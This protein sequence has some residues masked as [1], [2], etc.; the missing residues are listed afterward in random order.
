MSEIDDGV[1]KYDRN[2]YTKCD[3]L[4]P[5]E[6]SALEYWREKLYKLKL[7]GEYQP[8]MIGYGNVSCR[9]QKSDS[10][11]VITG[12][13]TGKFE[14][15]CGEH[16]TR[17]CGYDLAKNILIANGPL[18]ASSEALTHA[19][20]YESSNQI[21]AVFHIHDQE[22]WN[23]MLNDSSCNITAKQIPYG[24]LEMAQA[25][26]YFSKKYL[27]GTLAMAGH[28]DGIIA[29]G[30]TLDEAGDE[31]LKLVEKFKT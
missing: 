20:I 3:A 8:E 22:I 12:T 11:F 25:V 13:Q 21:Q 5:D 2:F 23:G 14:K 24:T 28:A 7:I 19:A 4:Q 16:Y 10:L 1:I 27:T 9:S 29:W 31:I 15:L 17:V 30:K 26:Q 18:E 6:Y